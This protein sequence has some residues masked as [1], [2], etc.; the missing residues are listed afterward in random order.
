MLR[1]WFSLLSIGICLLLPNSLLAQRSFPDASIQLHDVKFKPAEPIDPKKAS[2]LFVVNGHTVALPSTPT[3]I[4]SLAF[5]PDGKLLAAGKQHGRLVVWDV[6]SKAVISV[7]DTGFP[8]VGRVAFSPDSQFIAAAA[9]WGPSI[10]LWHISDGQLANTLDNTH[11]NVL[12]LIYPQTNLLIVFSGLTD[13]FDTTSGKLVR[14]FLNDRDPVLSTD[15]ST[16]VTVK[17]SN[18]IVRSTR[19]W[20][21]VGTLPKLVSPE[22]PV[23]WD[24]TQ[25]VFLFDDMTDDHLFVAARTSDGQMVPEDKLANLPKSSIPY[26]DFAAIEPQT[27]LVFGHSGGEVWALDLKTGKT[28]FSPQLLSNSAALSTDGTLLAGAME[29]ATPT[30]NQKDAGVLIWKTED[31][32]KACHMQ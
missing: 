26:E 17:D 23:F 19:D 18:L 29:P 13:L 10:K 15:G 21:V 28:C 12:Q 20:N 24:V 11:A 2:Q 7:I 4:N 5:S 31:L 3:Q 22:R 25:G 30:D 9:A 32:A 27:H 1:T 16:L 8:A 6:A 14:S